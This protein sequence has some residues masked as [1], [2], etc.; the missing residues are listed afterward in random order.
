M[1][2]LVLVGFMGSGKTSVGRRAAR[3][4]RMPFVDTDT[5]IEQRVGQPIQSIFDRDGEAAFRDIEAEVV[6]E[7]ADGPPSVISTGGGALLRP[8]NLVALQRRGIVIHLDVEPETVHKRTR[9]RPTRPLLAGAAD[10]LARIRELMAAR[11]GIYAPADAKVNANRRLVEDVL[12]DVICEWRRL[13][14]DASP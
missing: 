1:K 5:R 11:A 10:P 9:R 6:A 12:T 13:G 3:K 8:A 7:A 14:G 4:L 2:H